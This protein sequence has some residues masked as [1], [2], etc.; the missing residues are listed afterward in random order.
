MARAHVDHGDIA[1]LAQGKVN[2]PK[3]KATNIAR[4]R[5]VSRERLRVLSGEPS[6]Q[7]QQT[8][9]GGR[10]G[11]DYRCGARCR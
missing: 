8:L 4:R 9:Y 3:D 10:G 2:L 6:K 5:D 1:S 11:R 7:R